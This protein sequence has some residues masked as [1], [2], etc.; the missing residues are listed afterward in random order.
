MD[1]SENHPNSPRDR[2]ILGERIARQFLE[3]K[4]FSVVEVNCR[5]KFGEVDIV[6]VKEGI[7]HFV[8]VKSVSRENT[9]VA[10]H[11]GGEYRPE[12]LVHA[13]KVRKIRQ[14]AEAYLVSREIDAPAQI[15]ALAVELYPKQRKARCRLIEHAENL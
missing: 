2:G 8:E 5:T 13:G 10:S 11:E 6:A 12:D 3:R 1:T 15:D 4:G 7:W 14:V 9:L